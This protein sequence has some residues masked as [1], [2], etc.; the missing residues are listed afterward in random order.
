MDV[1]QWIQGLLKFQRTDARLD[2]IHIVQKLLQISKVFSGNEEHYEALFHTHVNTWKGHWLLA[3]IPECP[4]SIQCKIAQSKDLELQQALLNK[5]PVPDSVFEI[6]IAK[7]SQDLR[8]D[9][10]SYPGLP[11]RYHKKLD[12]SESSD[13]V[14]EDYQKEVIAPK[15]KLFSLYRRYQEELLNNPKS[16]LSFLKTSK[17]DK[18]ALLYWVQMNSK[19]LWNK[20]SDHLEYTQNSPVSPEA[21]DKLEHKLAFTQRHLFFGF[22]LCT[23]FAAENL[24]QDSSSFW[25]EILEELRLTQTAP[26]FSKNLYRLMEEMGLLRFPEDR[27]LSHTYQLD[28]LLLHTPIPKRYKKD[29]EQSV[30]KSRHPKEALQ[31]LNSA[32]FRSVLEFIEYHFAY[33]LEGIFEEMKRGL[34]H[35]DSSLSSSS[36]SMQNEHSLIQGQKF[37]LFDEEDSTSISIEDHKNIDRSKDIWSWSVYLPQKT[38]RLR[39]PQ[40][41]MCLTNLQTMTQDAGMHYTGNGSSY[42]SSST[43]SPMHT[44]R[45]NRSLGITAEVETSQQ[46][47]ELPWPE[48]SVLIFKPGVN[49]DDLALHCETLQQETLCWILCIEDAEEALCSHNDEA[50]SWLRLHHFEGGH[51][52]LFR[53]NDPHTLEGLK[54]SW[55]NNIHETWVCSFEMDHK[56]YT[57]IPS[58]NQWKWKH[59]DESIRVWETWPIFHDPEQYIRSIKW[60]SNEK[61]N[62]GQSLILQS[63]DLDIMRYQGYL[64]PGYQ[65]QLKHIIGSGTL[66]LL[67]Q[68]QKVIQNYRVLKLPQMMLFFPSFQAQENNLVLQATGE[69]WQLYKK[70]HTTKKSCIY[71]LIPKGQGQCQFHKSLDFIYKE[72]KYPLYFCYESYAPS[73][74][75]ISGLMTQG[76]KKHPIYNLEKLLQD[77]GSEGT[78]LEFSLP[79]K[80]LFSDSPEYLEIRLGEP[81][82]DQFQVKFGELNTKIISMRDENLRKLLGRAKNLDQDFSLNAK[83]LFED[84]EIPP[85]NCE[86]CRIT[87]RVITS[88]PQFEIQGRQLVV[89]FDELSEEFD[90][91]EPA[92]FLWEN[93]KDPLTASVRTEVKIVE[94]SE[95]IGVTFIAALPPGLE[96]QSFYTWRLRGAGLSSRRATHLKIEKDRDLFDVATIDLEK[97]HLLYLEFLHPAPFIRHNEWDLDDAIHFFSKEWKGTLPDAFQSKLQEYLGDEPYSGSIIPRLIAQTSPT[98]LLKMFWEWKNPQNPEEIDFLRNWLNDVDF[99]PWT[100]SSDSVKSILTLE[101]AYLLASTAGGI[102]PVEM[103][104]WRLLHPIY[105]TLPEDHAYKSILKDRFYW[106][107]NKKDPQQVDFYQIRLDKDSKDSLE[108]AWIAWRALWNEETRKQDHAPIPDA[109]KSLTSGTSQNQD[110]K[111]GG[112]NIIAWAE[113]FSSESQKWDKAQ[114][115]FQNKDALEPVINSGKELFA[116]ALLYYE[117]RN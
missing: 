64:V 27:S 57:P 115:F 10:V 82:I 28:S 50:I 14:Y 32:R 109:G 33:A 2:N 35:S 30:K 8:L 86:L 84:A 61:E 31:N 71:I 62:S 105:L 55:N 70:G 59:R 38:R 88:P 52:S 94:N 15:R 49:N 29:W 53:L 47:W 56:Y 102:L 107:Q 1:N 13:E 116:M 97:A 90:L 22:V 5:W 36:T 18:K 72:K 67:D 20:I 74:K 42:L 73:G 9:L 100:V 92:Y 110:W 3:Q 66:K 21:Y 85:L 76:D 77:T 4:E 80:K 65:N 78:Y 117:H 11:D 48:N 39:H 108:R 43:E 104:W 89:Y 87:N 98:V 99:S 93:I 68:H 40:W 91:N 37:R 83:L 12:Y 81:A 24:D 17:S 41:T 26:V 103:G 23:T 7:Q 34:F 69:R 111:H 95:E 45:L 75:I 60:E 54:I 101:M 44:L 114:L 106:F 46:R 16:L 19:I 112:K 51:W 63:H 58:Q 6:L 25:K 79:P 113:W 96:D